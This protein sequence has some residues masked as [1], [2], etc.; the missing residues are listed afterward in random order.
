[1]CNNNMIINKLCTEATK[2][3][4]E[5]KLAAVILKGTKM[6]SNPCCNTQRNTYRGMCRGSLHAEAHAMITYYGKNLSFDNK[7]GWCLLPRK[8]YKIHKT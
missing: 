7:H 6:I 2:S 1:M 8:K 5:Q 4:L 3:K